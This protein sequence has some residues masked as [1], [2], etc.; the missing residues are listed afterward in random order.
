[1]R[2]LEFLKTCR[3]KGDD[4]KTFLSIV[5]ENDIFIDGDLL[6]K[7]IPNL[8]IVQKVGHA[9]GNLLK[10]LAGRLNWKT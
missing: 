9:P 4:A 2:G 1:M 10:R 5:G 7:H 3:A 8:D 6:R